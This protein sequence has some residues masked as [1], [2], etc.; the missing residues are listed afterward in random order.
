M[1]G[2]EADPKLSIRHERAETIVRLDER[3]PARRHVDAVELEESGVLVIVGEQ[4]LAGEVA[5]RLLHVGPDAGPG[6]QR[7]NVTGLQI[8]AKRLPVLVAALFTEEDH[9]TVVVEPRIEGGDIAVGHAGDGPRLCHIADR[10]HPQVQDLVDRGEEGEPSTVGADARPRPR[11]LGE[12]QPA[13]DQRDGPDAR[14]GRLRTDGGDTV[15][16]QARSGGGADEELA[17]TER[18]PVHM[19]RATVAPAQGVVNVPVRRCNFSMLLRSTARVFVVPI[20]APP[21]DVLMDAWKSHRP[22]G[23]SARTPAKRSAPGRY[24]SAARTACGAGE[25]T[26]RSVPFVMRR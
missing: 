12:Q 18:A 15:Q 8:N 13:R 11:R 6:R 21:F 20:Q 7:E 22:T 24:P 25:V 2:T 16:E 3:A 5:G 9:V 26:A 1:R 14:A 4:D 19:A 23:H 17:S 10:A